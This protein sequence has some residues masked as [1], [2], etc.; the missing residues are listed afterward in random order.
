MGLAFEIREIVFDAGAAVGVAGDVERLHVAGPDIAGDEA[1]VESGGAAGE[2]F[3]GFGGLEGGDEVDDWAEDADGV[4][5]FF[6]GGSGSVGAF[7]EAGEA[8]GLAGENGHGEAVTGHA[9]GVNPRPIGT[10]RHRPA[11]IAM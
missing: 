3:D 4:A 5:G 8:G 1:V 7:E 10:E 2:E 9:G 11:K 6:V